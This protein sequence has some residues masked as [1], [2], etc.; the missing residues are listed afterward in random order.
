[1]LTNRQLFLNHLAQTSD[2]PLLLDI[3][4]AEGINIFDK[5]GKK[6]ID[7]ISGISVSNLGHNNRK[8]ID[9]IKMQLDKHLHLMVYGEYIQE[10]QIQLAKK[11]TSLL[12]CPLESVYYVNSGT[13]ANEGALKLA[14]RFTGKHKIV[15]FN[16]AYH[17]STHGSL[18]VMGNE[19]YKNPFRPL[20]PG[21]NIL[22]YNDSKALNLIDKETAAVII[23]PI[24][25]ESGVN[26][27]SKKFINDL[28][29][30]CNKTGALLIMDE[31]QTGFGRTGKM[32]G[33]E[34]FGIIPDIL[35]VA[36]AFGGGMPLGAFISSKEIMHCLA[37]NPALGHITTFG[38]HPVCCAAGLESLNILTQDDIINTV[39][40]KANL[41]IKKL[42]SKNIKGIR[43]KGLLMAVQLDNFDQ[44]QSVIKD[45]LQ[46][47][48]IID[49]FLFCNSAIRI[50]PPLIITENEIN[51]ACKI[52]NRNIDKL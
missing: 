18:S 1:M 8:I 38:G 29:V 36:K 4:K 26:V 32:F 24:Q 48:I 47:G 52:I 43:N 23:E 39:N 37:D 27:P 7:L 30:K 14:K 13:E 42:N 12:P 50:A 6:Y 49:W 16:N 15:S 40:S 20:L 22:Q 34:H 17:G 46:D 11:L 41:I 28:K 10:T 33:F 3:D 44:V 35:T 2:I 5:S 31:I 9:A 25:A 19:M 51:E 21:I 45:C